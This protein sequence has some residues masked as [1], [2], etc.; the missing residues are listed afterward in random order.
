MFFKIAIDPGYGF[1]KGI[2]QNGDMI[3]IPS[4]VGNAH[5]RSLSNLLGAFEQDEM[6]QLHV[7]YEDDS[8]SE[9]FFIGEL[10]KESKNA[11]YNFDQNKVNHLSTKVLIATATAILAPQMDQKIWIGV[12]LP[13][14]FFHSQKEEL[15][16]MLQNFSAKITLVHQQREKKIR[17]DRV[18]VYAQGA[19]AIYDGL[20]YPNGKPKYPEMMKRGSMIASVNWGTRT[21]DVVVFEVGERF[22][23]KPE[24]S[25][26]IDDAGAME[27]RR[28]IQ[29]AFNQKTGSTISLVEAERIIEN[30]GSI[31]YNRAEH[32]FVEHIVNAKRAVVRL[33][34]DSLVSRWGNQAGFIRAIFLSGGTVLDVKDT[35]DLSKLPALAILC[36]DPQ[37]SD[38]RGMFH[39]M[40]GEEIAEK[41]ETQN[42][43]AMNHQSGIKM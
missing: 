2:S 27:I 1:L 35:L 34:T 39:L 17:F 13:L 32:D 7:K 38:A 18:S 43:Y 40:R 29:K 30:G 33:V 8:I 25:F 42:T 19:T 11:T 10:A 12:G 14:E 22:K 3:R 28:Q 15:K 26:T 23:I 16:R 24:L 37:F 5:D 31:Y 4:L 21:V 6:Q 41:R 36:E 9:E 20:L